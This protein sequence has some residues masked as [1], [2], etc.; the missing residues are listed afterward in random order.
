MESE[1]IID[2]LSVSHDG[3]LIAGAGRDGLVK[4]WEVNTG[5]LINTFRHDA[6]V[7]SIAFSPTENILA[8]GSQDT[9]VKLWDTVI[10]TE[11][12]TI[13][14]PD[15][16]DAVAF[17]PDGK[18]LAWRG[19]GTHTL[20]DT[21]NL[22]DVATQ[23]LIAVYERPT[24][25]FHF[26][27]CLALSPD[28]KTFVTVD[29]IYDIVKVWDINTGNT[30]DLGHI[31][32]SPISFDLP[33]IGL[34]PISF[35][36][37]STMLAT[38]GTRGVK[39]WDVNTGRN[40]ANIPIKPSSHVQLVSFSPNGRTLAYRVVGKSLPDY[41]MFQPKHRLVSLKIHQL[42]I[43]RFHLTERLLHRLRGI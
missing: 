6:R 33:N 18:I 15:V 14:N 28:N 35:S 37:D 32:L 43:G 39:L 27:D 11:I 2:T 7:K 21:I 8:S 42:T 1:Y 23:S 20:P 41:G 38:G 22:W 17:S 36:P 3:A 25:I 19:A 31:G 9:T 13:Q 40:V 29:H 12:Y 5:Q 16:I 24:S 30:I 26:I 10:G 4:V 34:T